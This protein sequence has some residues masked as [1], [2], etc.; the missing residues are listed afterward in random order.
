LG[1]FFGSVSGFAFPLI[2]TNA[3]HPNNARLKD[4]SV[5]QEAAFSVSAAEGRFSVSAAE[6]RFSVS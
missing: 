1:E 4:H 6:G 2:D 5:R 3:F